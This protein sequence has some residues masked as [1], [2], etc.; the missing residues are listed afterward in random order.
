MTIKR[1][2]FS[3]IDIREFDNVID[4]RSPSEFEDDHVPSS[5]NLP[6]L[7]NAERETVGT[8]YKQRSKFE[9]KK[10]GASKVSK[11]ISDHLK[12]FIFKKSRD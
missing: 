2:K 8:I 3:D 6:V 4:V 1:V 7:S 12:G 11:N 10:L 5:I 9:A